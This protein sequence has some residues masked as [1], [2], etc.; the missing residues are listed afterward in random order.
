[1]AGACC[2]IQFWITYH[3]SSII[4]TWHNIIAINQTIISKGI[5]TR[6]SNEF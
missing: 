6:E 1:M 4:I 3:K 5:V 2:N